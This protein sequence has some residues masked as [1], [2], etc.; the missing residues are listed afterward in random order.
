[1]QR[2]GQ[3]VEVLRRLLLEALDGGPQQVA[4]VGVGA[5]EGLQRAHLR[6]QL[7]L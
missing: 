7:R 1:V 5:E 2:A 6:A 3:L 4:G